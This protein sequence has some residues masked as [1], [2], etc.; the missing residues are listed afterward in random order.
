MQPLN[1]VKV[2]ALS[3]IYQGPYCTLL[4]AFQGADVIKVEPLGGE[5][6]RGRAEQGDETH[7][8]LMLNSNKKDVTLNLK[9]DQ[10]KRLFKE[11]VKKTDVVVEN[12]AAGVME[13]LEL[14]YEELSEVNPKIIYARGK[15]FGLE[16][17]YKD[18]L[19][20]DLTVQAMGGV[21]SSTG[22]PDQ[23]PVKAGPAIADFLGGAHL[24]AGIVT[25]LYQREQTGEG[26]VVEVSMHDT[27]YPSLA[28]P[29][30]GVYD[31]EDVPERTGNRHSGLQISPYN[32]YPASDGYIAIICV[33]ERHWENLV[34]LMD[35]EEL[36]EDPRFENRL[37]RAE[38]MEE[39]D[40]TIANWS[41][42]F[43]KEDLFERLDEAEVPCAPVR[44]VKEVAEDP[45]L[46]SREMMVEVDHPTAGVRPVPG[47]PVRLHGAD[48]VE[49]QPSPLLSEHTEEVL[50]SMVGLNSSEIESLRQDDVIE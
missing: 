43:E 41:Q 12:F 49:V 36:L 19:A 3:Q 13:E 31:R 47:N 48:D 21:M 7:P 10:G 20:M 40:E 34:R 6:M 18:H 45:H 42:Q 39:I 29:M 17:P 8:F 44:T 16:G 22:F 30:A 27:I 2:L 11:M 33:R 14:G 46:L 28:S 35:R 25:A 32:V 1:D 15:G 37:A 4:L 26:Q 9:T 24:L 38:H 23:P 5:A 50:R